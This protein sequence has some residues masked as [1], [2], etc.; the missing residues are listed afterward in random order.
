ME[1]CGREYLEK[2]LIFFILNM[3]MLSLC[4]IY[5]VIMEWRG[6]LLRLR[7]FTFAKCFYITKLNCDP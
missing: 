2:C 3:F 7:V 4:F 6:V 1:E 5:N